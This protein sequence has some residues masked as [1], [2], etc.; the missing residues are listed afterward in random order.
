MSDIFDSAIFD[1]VIFDVGILPVVMDMHDGGEADKRHREAAERR[2][3][4]L[5]EAMDALDPPVIAPVAAPPVTVIAFKPRA[6]SLDA[7][8]AAVEAVDTEDE[9]VMLLLEAA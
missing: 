8:R 7:I 4:Q 2:R 6:V 5:Q 9:D 1:G 3:R